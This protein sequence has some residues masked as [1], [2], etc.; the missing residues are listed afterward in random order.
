MKHSALFIGVTAA[1]IASCSVQEEVFEVPQQDDV[2]FYASF[3]RPTQD[4]TKVYVNEDLH[5][6][7][8]ADDRVSIFNQNTYNQQYKFLGETGDNSGEFAK[9]EGAEFVTGNPIANVVS[10]Y[11]YQESATILESEVMTLTLPAE[12]HFADKSFGLVVCLLYF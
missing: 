2:R 8:T 7:W 6:R 11:P 3:E 5:L 12:Q 4:G 1:L 10:V 9:V